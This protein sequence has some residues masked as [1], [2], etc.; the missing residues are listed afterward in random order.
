MADLSEPL[1]RFGPLAEADKLRPNLQ[2]AVL[3]LTSQIQTSLSRKNDR[4][5]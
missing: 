5:F 1:H 2:L 4:G 3:D